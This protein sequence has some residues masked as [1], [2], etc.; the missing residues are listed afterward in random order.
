MAALPSQTLRKPSS[1]ASSLSTRPSPARLRAPAGLAALLL[2]AA[3]GAELVAR[4]CRCGRRTGAFPDREAELLVPAAGAHPGVVG[5]LAPCRCVDFLV[6][7]QR[8]AQSAQPLQR[9]QV[10]PQV[11]FEKDEPV[12]E[13]A[14]PHDVAG[15]D[16]ALGLGAGVVLADRQD[17]RP[18]AGGRSAC[19]PTPVDS[20]AKHVRPSRD[21]SERPGRQRDP[22]ELV[23]S[24][25]QLPVKVQVR[26]EQVQ[27][28]PVQMLLQLRPPGSLRWPRAVI[29]SALSQGHD[30]AARNRMSCVLVPAM[31]RFL[32]CC[33]RVKTRS[34]PR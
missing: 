7:R 26:C 19:R 16:L 6:R 8:V 31:V 28:E 13:L 2:R 34:P 25:A 11:L 3:A 30:L 1:W 23:R 14:H 21:S 29:I 17:I 33:S 22:V 32:S 4:R 9:L 5:R 20:H 18:P 15:P 12:L 27:I 10:E 24:A